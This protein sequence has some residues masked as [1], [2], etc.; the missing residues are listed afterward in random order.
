MKKY[1]IIGDIHGYG[2]ELKS[3]LDKLGY[4]KDANGTYV[5]PEPDRMAVFT[6]DYIDRGRENF[7]VI[8][9]VRNMVD[10]GHARAIMGN[11]DLNAGL[12]HTLH[13]ETQKPL[14]KRDEKNVRQHQAYLDEHHNDLE[15]GEKNIAWLKS[16]PVCLELDGLRFVHAMWDAPSLDCLRKAGIMLDD[17]TIAPDRWPDMQWQ[18]Q[19]PEQT[20]EFKAIELLTKGF[21]IQLPLGVSFLDGDGHKRKKAR[22]KW[23]ANPDKPDL[24]FHEVVLDVPPESIPDMRASDEIKNEI[25]RLQQLEGNTVFFGHYWQRGEHPTVETNSAI[26]IDQSV[27][28]DGHL[29]A[30]TVTVEDGHMQDMVFTSVKSRPPFVPPPAKA[31]NAL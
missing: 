11:H 8:D 31:V 21:E 27:A 19:K 7:E 16:L 4:K 13:P 14:R 23:W 10:A 28:K 29:A 18:P 26:C 6:G 5:P 12:F 20:P 25:R 2:K 3:L 22:L 17:N 24:M 30:A 1:D 15:Q 9:I